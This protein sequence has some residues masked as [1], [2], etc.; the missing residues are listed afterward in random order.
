MLLQN[1]LQLIEPWLLQILKNKAL[2]I[3][4]GKLKACVEKNLNIF[5]KFLGVFAKV[6]S[7]CWKISWMKVAKILEIFEKIS[8]KVT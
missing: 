1:S 6:L 4:L 3:F 5:D 8:G 7:E 2:G